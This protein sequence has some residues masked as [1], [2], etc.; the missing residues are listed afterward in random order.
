MPPASEA[1][2]PAPER[3][4]D[5]FG[6][7]SGLN[8]H[9]T[10]DSLAYAYRAAAEAAGLALQPRIGMPHPPEAAHGRSENLAPAKHAPT[11]GV[12]AR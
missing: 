4:C 9:D 6:S 10:I 2:H 5:V 1:W 8:A 7:P 12:E 11:E 3:I